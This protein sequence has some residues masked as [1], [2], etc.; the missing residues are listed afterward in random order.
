MAL[1]A[2]LVLFGTGS[3]AMALHYYLQKAGHRIVAFCV[4]QAYLT[5]RTFLDCPV[6]PFEDLPA[7]Y[8]PDRVELMIAIGYAEVN[9][10]RARRFEQAKKMGYRLV[11]YL[12]PNA[13]LWDALQ[14]GENC[15][16]GELS[17]LQPF[18]RLGQ[19][20]F[21][22]SNCIIGHHSTIHDHCFLGSG[23]QLGGNVTIQDHSFIG[24]GAVIRNKIVIA[25]RSVIGAGAVILQNTRPGGVYLAAE[26][27]EMP[28][29]SDDLSP[30]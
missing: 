11:S 24:T 19:N 6:I 2:Q 12:S 8:P 13:I 29:D 23:V 9:Q 4:D 25:E 15:K 10:L 17:I 27:I 20:V 22:G 26:A 7:H 14:M 5:D 18:S 1:M 21:I 3:T 16:I 30:A 28:I